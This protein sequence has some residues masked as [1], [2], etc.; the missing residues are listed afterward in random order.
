MNKLNTLTCDSWKYR[1]GNPIIISKVLFVLTLYTPVN[2][3][4]EADKSI[5][6]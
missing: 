4:S 5:T 3:F 1:M 2:I 6:A